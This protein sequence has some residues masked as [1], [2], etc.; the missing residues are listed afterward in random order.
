MDECL[1]RIGHGQRQWDR[2]SKPEASLNHFL[3]ETTLPASSDRQGVVG[4]NE[5]P[6]ERDR[7]WTAGVGLHG[8][9]RRG[10]RGGQKMQQVQEYQSDECSDIYYDAEVFGEYFRSIE[11]LAATWV[12]LEK[13][14]R[15]TWQ[16]SGS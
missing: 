12:V 14:S 15:P 1:H 9:K 7:H 6:P 13:K 3:G 8:G 10:M 16:T 2:E 11:W 4:N 5:Y